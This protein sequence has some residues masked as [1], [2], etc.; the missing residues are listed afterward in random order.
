ML[1]SQK[2]IRIAKHAGSWY[3]SSPGKLDQELTNY[4]SQAEE[5]IPK[6]AKLKALIGP[7]AGLRYSGPT[8][9]W[10]YKNLASRA[11]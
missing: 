1:N 11:H 3:E 7:H 10:A 6:E 5:T 2:L 9:G 4:L 8:A